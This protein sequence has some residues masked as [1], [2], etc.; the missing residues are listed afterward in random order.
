LKTGGD[1]DQT[2]V[3]D[4]ELYKELDAQFNSLGFTAEEKLGV[5]RVTAAVLHMGEL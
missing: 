4:V 1:V 5:W 3:N 2:I